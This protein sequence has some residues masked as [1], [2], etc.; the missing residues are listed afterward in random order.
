MLQSCDG[1]DAKI[2]YKDAK[3]LHFFAP[4]AIA[5]QVCVKLTLI[6]S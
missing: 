4:L 3:L 1:K 5:G 2:K 6:T